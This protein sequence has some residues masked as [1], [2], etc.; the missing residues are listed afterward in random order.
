M[1]LHIPCCPGEGADAAALRLAVPEGAASAMLRSYRRCL[2]GLNAD[3][4]FFCRGFT[5]F[6]KDVES[7]HYP[8]S[9]PSSAARCDQLPGHGEPVPLTGATRIPQFFILPCANF[10]PGGTKPGCSE[11]HFT[12]WPSPRLLIPGWSSCA[13]FCTCTHSLA[14]AAAFCS[15]ERFLHPHKDAAGFAAAAAIRG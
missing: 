12:A 9:S 2:A 14:A 6:S 8:C 10:G 15:T 7:F 5:L 4:P 11:S 1:C 3:G 13:G